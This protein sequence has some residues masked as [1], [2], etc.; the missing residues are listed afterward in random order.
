M[1][2]LIVPDI[3]GRPFYKKVLNSNLPIVFL[4]D[5]LDPYPYELYTFEE[6]L[7]NFKEIIEFKKENKQRVTLLI[8]N[9]CFNSLWQKNWASRFTPSP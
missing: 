1:E 5:Y 9:H 8:G 4:G 6:S 7:N 3:H 2:I